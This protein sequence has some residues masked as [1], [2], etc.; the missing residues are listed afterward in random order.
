VSVST[1]PGE[2][3]ADLEPKPSKSE[4]G[5]EVVGSPAPRPTE[6]NVG[7]GSCVRSDVQIAK[8]VVSEFGNKSVLC[9]A[10]SY[11]I[12]DDMSPLCYMNVAIRCNDDEARKNV[13][14]L[15]DT[16]SEMSLLHSDLLDDFEYSVVG[17]V[18]LR[19]FC[20]DSISADIVRINVA[21]RM[22][23]SDNS[24]GVCLHC[25]VVPDLSDEM[26]LAENAISRLSQT[27]S[28]SKLQSEDNRVSEFG[29]GGRSD[30]TTDDTSVDDKT[31]TCNVVGVQG[32]PALNAAP[33]SE[34]EQ[35]SGSGEAD[36]LAET[37]SDSLVSSS[38]LAK[39][40][41]NDESPYS[42]IV[43]CDG[44]KHHVHANKLRKF[45]VRV[46]SVTCDPVVCE[47]STVGNVSD[48]SLSLHARCIS[49][50]AVVYDE[51][52]DFGDL[53][54]VPDSLSEPNYVILPSEQIDLV[55]IGHLDEGQQ[56]ELLHLLDK[57]PE[58]FSDKPGFTD[59]VTH[60][61]PLKDGFRPERLP[62]YRVPEKLKPEVD[63]QIQEMLQN[64]I[65][66]KSNSPMASPMVCVLKGKEGC[67]GVRLAVD[68]RY[69][70]SFTHDDSYP[71]PDLQSIFQHVG[72]SNIISVADCKAGYWQLPMKEDQKW[73]TAFVCDAGVLS[74]IVHLLV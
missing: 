42:Y 44:V 28:V 70:N 69:V 21:N 30:T 24:D 23:Q 34:C 50:C 67:D 74:L 46:E 8:V 63:R 10:Q 55:S 25:A 33:P 41:Q 7:P 17:C 36:V 48:E 47:F 27:K 20:G 72:H 26:I 31:H 59:V 43:E 35:T 6:S 3:K 4:V 60:T 61:I 54:V 13:S 64:G 1:V 22:S 66:R 29:R 56:K 15:C 51:D 53:H 58:C 52:V 9:K 68:Y 45:H 40:Q 16:G 39:E 14:A 65:I 38:M 11:S 73:L 49:S 19:P 37:N 32:D 5:E 12:I 57:Y 18:Q 2:A 62:A 71:L